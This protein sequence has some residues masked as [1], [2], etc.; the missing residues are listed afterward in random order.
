MGTTIYPKPTHTYRTIHAYFKL[1]TMVQKNCLAKRTRTSCT[2]N[3]QQQFPHDKGTTK[4]CQVYLMEWIPSPHGQRSDKIIFHEKQR[5]CCCGSDQPT[6]RASLSNSL[7]PPSIHRQERK[8]VGQSCTR[9]IIRLL[10]TLCKFTT[11]YG[12][13]TF[14]TLKDR[15]EK[16]LRSSVVYN[17]SCPGC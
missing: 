17:F 13:K 3:L 8:D 6:R 7:D 2:Q 5:R 10:K 9:K 4:N 16:E 15:T 12:T 1:H 11:V 14:P